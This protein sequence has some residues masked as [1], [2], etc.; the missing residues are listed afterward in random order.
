M[1]N[2]LEP[3]KQQSLQDPDSPSDPAPTPA[4]R[5]PRASIHSRGPRLRPW[6]KQDKTGGTEWEEARTI[7]DEHS[8]ANTRGTVGGWCSL[9]KREAE[10]TGWAGGRAI[11]R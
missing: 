9:S 3:E 6:S 2:L 5:G 7:D 1:R 4:E 11:G 10:W 8:T